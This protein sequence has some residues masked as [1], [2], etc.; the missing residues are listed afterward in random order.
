MSSTRQRLLVILV[1]AFRYDY[2]SEKYTPFLYSLS[3]KHSY[4]PLRPILGY[5][6]SIRAT[7]FTGVY[8]E[9]HNYWIMYKYSPET[10]PFKIFKKF[11]F[12]DTFPESFIKRGGRFV[13]SSSLC[14]IM[15]R[16]NGYSELSIQNI[17]FK[18][19]D[20]FDYSLKKSMLSVGAFNNFPTIFDILRNNEIK[21]AYIDSS[22]FGWRYYF[23][24]SSKLWKKLL[25][26]VDS[27]P[28]DV[29]LI[30][31]YL[32][33]LDHFAHRH[34]TTSPVFLKELKSVDKTVEFVIEKVEKRFGDVSTII[35]SDHGMA[36]AINYV[37]FEWLKKEYGFGRDFLFFLDSTMVRLWYL[38]EKGKRVRE[39]IEPLN[40]GRFLS[41]R[42]KK[43]LKINFKHRY[44][45]DDIFLID[46]PYNIFPNF[47]SWLTP[48]AMHAYHPL[49]ESQTGMAMFIGEEFEKIRKD[50]EPI[51]H[52]EF[53][54]TILDYFNLEVPQTCRGKFLLR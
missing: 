21:Y 4:L 39:K 35:F 20:Y 45:G 18:I 54:P 23:A 42:D 13:L 2:L 47:V 41:E 31:V 40:Y 36:D 1:D 11:N 34:G 6:D 43:E 24:S 16:K 53:M 3:K 27:L 49:E 26:A 29:G 46:P 48:Y 8:P 50:S 14:K 22:K 19:I 32:H 38:N 17:P 33:H 12:I 9:D 30:F 52:I 37:S 7:I 10:S 28:N 44:Y 25:E 51:H 5:S 15:A